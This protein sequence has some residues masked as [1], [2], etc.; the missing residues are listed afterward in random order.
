MYIFIY[1]CVNVYTRMDVICKHNKLCLSD[2]KL[3]KFRGAD[4]AFGGSCSWTASRLNVA[5]AA[6]GSELRAQ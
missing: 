3:R 5:V 6:V 4:V 1:M 2:L